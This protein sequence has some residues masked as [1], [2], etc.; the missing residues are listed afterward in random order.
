MVRIQ[1]EVSK[2]EQLAII[3]T[4][5]EE[6][7]SVDHLPWN[8]HERKRKS[9]DFLTQVLRKSGERRRRK[10]MLVWIYTNNQECGL[11]L[12]RIENPLMASWCVQLK[13]KWMPGCLNHTSKGKRKGFWV[14][15]IY[16]YYY[17]YSNELKEK[18][19]KR[20]LKLRIFF[21]M[22]I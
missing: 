3:Y 19:K 4:N 18:E 5:N 17:Y 20:E 14:L 16:Y 15:F 8:S 11:N 13:K 22:C 12:A 21:I 7:R 6:C 1:R 2:K 9:M 10:R